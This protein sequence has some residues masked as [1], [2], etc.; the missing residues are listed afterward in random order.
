MKTTL[1]IILAMFM[2][3]ATAAENAGSTNALNA[4]TKQDQLINQML[5]VSGMKRSLQELSM[6][7]AG[8]L[9]QAAMQAKPSE[10]GQQKL[11][12]LLERTF[13]PDIFLGHV[14]TELKKNYNE[15]RYM[16]VVQLLSAPLAQRMV[17][18]E[19][20]DPTPEELQ[21]F[22]AQITKTPLSP[23]RI[24]LIQQLDDAM[25]ASVFVDRITITT[26]T[27]GALISGGDCSKARARVKRAIAENRSDIEKASRSSTQIVL[28]FLYR[29]VSIA[30]LKAYLKM[31][32]NID[33]KW[34]MDIATAALVE[35]LEMSME[36]GS[37][38]I[39][40]I[41]KTHAPKK[42]MFAPKCGQSL[43]PDQDDD[44]SA[45]KKRV[46]RAPG[47]RLHSGKAGTLPG[48][49]IDLRACLDL[50]TPAET[51][52]CAER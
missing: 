21:A 13:E 12:K 19:A 29:D 16:N 17:D 25:Q 37:R 22:Y 8:G 34:V 30:D 50:A 20:H 46:T 44:V 3:A 52:A 15:Q 10:N 36:Q 9:M 39:A 48:P 2:S 23:A 33:S 18:L 28:S 26:I 42:T 43:S 45:S 31:S 1:A 41:L 7:M 4:S 32:K 35:Q 24:S 47:V 6:Q 5:T 11:I 38:A 49:E 27:A 51:I 14:S 40:K